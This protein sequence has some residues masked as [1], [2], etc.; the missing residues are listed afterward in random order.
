[1]VSYLGLVHGS[2]TG[3][4]CRGYKPS[5]PC[6]Q[7][8]YTERQKHRNQSRLSE[9]Q[10]HFLSE[11]LSPPFQRGQEEKDRIQ[12]I[13]CQPFLVPDWG[14]DRCCCRRW[15]RG[16]RTRC[17]PR[18]PDVSAVNTQTDK[19]VSNLMFYAQSTRT[20]ISGQ[21]CRRVSNLMLY[22]HS[23][24]TVISGQTRRRVS[25]LTLYTQS[26]RTDISGQTCRW[27]STL[28]FYAQSTSP[29]ISR[30]TR[31]QVNK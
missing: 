7:V 31:R 9:N 20:V 17:C 1:M 4:T 30:Q 28:I 12:Y 21:T 6:T 27:V 8:R 11:S 18:W 16:T 5:T 19:K 25:N 26:T 10:H 23:T 13:P 22:T 24:R 2:H 14:R 15:G 3:Q 29:V